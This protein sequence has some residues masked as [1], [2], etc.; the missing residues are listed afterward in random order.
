MRYHAGAAL[1]MVAAAL[2]F[3]ADRPHAW[4]SAL[5]C[6]L[7]GGCVGGLIVAYNL[8]IYGTLLDPGSIG[9]FSTKFLLPHLGFYAVALMAIWPALLLAPVLDRSRLRWLIRGV[10]GFYLVFL[11]TYYFYDRAPG[12]L[13]TLVIGQRLLQVA[14]P[15]WIISYAGVIDDWVAKP[16]RRWLGGRAWTALVA[17]ACVGLLAGTA[18]M[19]S[20]HQDHLN[21]LA[22]WRDA[23]VAAIPS[24][25]LVVTNN[26]LPKLF[27]IPSGLPPYRLRELDFQDQPLDHSREIEQEDRPWYLAI[28]PRALGSPSPKAARDL[29]D[30]YHMDPV[31]TSDPNLTLYVSQPMDP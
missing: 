28:L 25:S 23:M 19:F 30:R 22:R 29:L 1:P 21:R 7:G 12:W 26:V 14:L 10:C 5:L 11:S 24:G 2:Y 4:R 16:L 20:R 9:T 15:L 17:L 31:P 6:L 3:T 18:I 13:G 8:A 27:G